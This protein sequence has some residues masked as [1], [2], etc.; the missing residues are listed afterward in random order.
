MLVVPA[1]IFPCSKQQSVR[2]T[3]L[4]TE[5]AVE[6]HRLRSRGAP[7]GGTSTEERCTAALV[8]EIKA[9]HVGNK[10]RQRSE[11]GLIYVT[12]EIWLAITRS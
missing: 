4:F 9:R 11:A 8:P 3:P 6:V 10:L 5:I 1:T 12:A 2:V 7:G